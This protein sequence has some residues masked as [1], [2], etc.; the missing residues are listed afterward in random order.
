[1]SDSDDS[2]LGTWL[3]RIGLGSWWRRTTGTVPKWLSTTEPRSPE[4]RQERGEEARTAGRDQP[5]DAARGETAR[6]SSTPGGE[7]ASSGSASGRAVRPAGGTGENASI[8]G[9]RD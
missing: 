3:F 8:E 6:A 7:D 5:A 4:R 1:S 2:H 9:A